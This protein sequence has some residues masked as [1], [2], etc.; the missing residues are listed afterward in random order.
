LAPVYFRLPRI[1]GDAPILIVVD[2][3]CAFPPYGY[4]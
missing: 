3:M 2:A 4:G 1:S